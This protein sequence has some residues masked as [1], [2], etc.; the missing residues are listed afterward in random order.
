MDIFQ[1]CASIGLV[2][3]SSRP[4]FESCCGSCW[5]RWDGEAL[6]TEPEL[7]C[8]HQPTAPA[9]KVSVRGGGRL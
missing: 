3:D 7:L 8:T 6:T 2:V 4:L 1:A 5:C 9:I